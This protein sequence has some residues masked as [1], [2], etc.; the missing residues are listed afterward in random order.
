VIRT[1]ESVILDDASAPNP[2]STNEYIRRTH[3]RSILCV[4]LM[5]QATLIGVLY[6]ENTLASHVFTPQRLSVLELLSSQAAISLENARLYADLITENHERQTAEEALRASDERWRNLFE[7]APAGIALTGADGKFAAANPALQRMVGYTEAELLGLSA[8]DITHEDDLHVTRGIIAAHV[9]GRPFT[10][11]FEKR[12]RRKDGGV[13]WADVS[14]FLVPVPGSSPILGGVIIDITERKRAENELRRSE[15]ALLDAQRI[16][17]TGSW[18]WN[19]ATDQVTWSAELRR[20]LG[21]DP[22]DPELPAA[23]YVAMVHPDD[24]PG[25]REVID[26]A[27]RERGGFEYEYR[28]VLCNGSVKHLH[29]VGRPDVTES[30][31]LEFVGVVM[32]VTE[33]RQAEEA[34]RNAQTEL[35]RAARLTTMG[36]LAASIAHEVNQP[37]AAIVM[38]GSAGLRWLDQTAPDL[39]EVRNA[40]GRVVS[41]G[42]RAGDVIHGLRGLAGK[43]GPQL[44]TL[45]VDDVVHEVLALTH[46]ELQRYGIAL[47]TN[48]AA[49]DRPVRGDRVQ[50]QQVLLNLI[51]NGVDAM[52][53][54]TEHPR[55]LVVSSAFAERRSV[56]VS[57]EDSGPGVDPAIAPRIFEPFFT[58]KADGLGMG[59][60]ICRSII[61]AHGGQ[62]WAAPGVRHGTVFHFTVPVVAVRKR[63]V[64]T[65]D[66]HLSS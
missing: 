22:S 25:F 62:L 3:A 55:E 38:N 61:A 20:I 4:P 17:N 26:R 46:S 45:D 15:A 43:A 13:I 42:K 11:R 19:I 18:R 10:P 7:H 58:T 27:V 30:G 29:S 53:G 63:R 44:A 21:F 2:F 48:L 24:Q 39:D 59:L 31:E 54:V 28:M 50:L 32:D 9:A 33:R 36:E 66:R 34:L 35:T 23:E 41:D 14:T 8:A 57:V 1:R 56:L 37:L 47:R 65:D 64:R 52:K 5:K 60:S 12:Y 16:S 40:L 51:L 49:G 6:L